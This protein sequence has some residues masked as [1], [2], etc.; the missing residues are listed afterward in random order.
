MA[1]QGVDTPW[2]IVDR[3][4]FFFFT[5]RTSCYY[6]PFVLPFKQFPH[7]FKTST[8]WLCHNNPHKVVQC[9]LL[10][11]T[12]VARDCSFNESTV[13]LSHCTKQQTTRRM[14]E[15]TFGAQQHIKRAWPN[16]TS[17]MRNEAHS[18]TNGPE[19]EPA[20]EHGTM[21]RTDKTCDPVLLES[22]RNHFIP[23]LYLWE[24]SPLL[25]NKKKA[26]KQRCNNTC[27]A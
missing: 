15:L 27:K 9:S 20:S 6:D 10:K 23:R 16:K 12:S 25:T 24:K 4:I 1:Q 3:C 13:L 17:F 11:A 5:I 8:S 14:L 19:T 7:P 2:R 26:Q 22:C 21:R 18:A